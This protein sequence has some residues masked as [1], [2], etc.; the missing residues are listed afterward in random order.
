M[1]N[2]ERAVVYLPLL[3]SVGLI[4]YAYVGIRPEPT[5]ARRIVPESEC[6]YAPAPVEHGRIFEDV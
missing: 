1:T 5:P 4:L 2:R 3:L 6:P